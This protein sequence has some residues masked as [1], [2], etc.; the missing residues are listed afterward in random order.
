MSVH[1]P[2]VGNVGIYGSA[3]GGVVTTTGTVTGWINENAM[4]IGLGLSLLS[5]LIGVV[6]KVL[7]G[8]RD[9]RHHRERLEAER[10]QNAQQHESLRA[11]LLAA[12]RRGD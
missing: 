10:I 5:L 6:F 8:I 2:D 1:T 12:V 11:E 9:E 7:A 3:V 4:M